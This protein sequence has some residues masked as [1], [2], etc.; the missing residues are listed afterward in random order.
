M[1][2]YSITDSFSTRYKRSQFFFD[3]N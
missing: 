2:T 3:Q 1:L